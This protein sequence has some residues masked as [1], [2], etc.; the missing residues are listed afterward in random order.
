MD[1]CVYGRFSIE[2][3]EKWITEKFSAVE[4]KNVEI[5]LFNDPL[6]YPAENLGKLIKYVPVKDQDV[7]CLSFVVD[8]CG[9]DFNSKPLN[10]F[11]HLVGHEGE[12]SLLSY[13]KDND[14]V[15]D[16]SSSVDSVLSS[17]SWF[18]IEMTLTKKGFLNY[19]KVIESC[20]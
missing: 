4:N 3:L 11:S 18:E 12:N 6:I 1:L 8:Y 17:T 16:L 19:E 9:G 20:F 15:S 13:L 2:T 5:P 14:W 10:Y 7:L